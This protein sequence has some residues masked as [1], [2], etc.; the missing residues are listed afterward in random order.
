MDKFRLEM[1]AIY[2]VV[3]ED[4]DSQEA[5]GRKAS[6]AILR[7]ASR[8]SH[9]EFPFGMSVLAQLCACTNG[10]LTAIFP[11]DP[12]PVVLPVLNINLP[13]TRK[14]SGHR[15]GMVIGRQIDENVVDKAKRLARDLAA[16]HLDHQRVEAAARAV[17]VE[18][19]IM[20]SFTEA[21]FF[22]RCAGDWDQVKPNELHDLSGRVYFGTLV[23]L[24][25]AY[26]FLKMVG[27]VPQ[28]S[29][30]GVGGGLCWRARAGFLAAAVL[31]AVFPALVARATRRRLGVPRQGGLPRAGRR[32]ELARG[33]EG[34]C[35]RTER[36]GPPERGCGRGVRIEQA[37][38]NRRSS[39][40][41]EDRW[42][43]WAGFRSHRFGR[44][45]WKRTPCN[46]GADAPGLPRQ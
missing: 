44:H 39:D 17:R 45:Q 31:G 10:A 37:A 23:N 15:V 9:H 26:R 7:L 1:T 2:D 21:A 46:C 42:R 11:G 28:Q 6:Q 35:R 27:L 38:A 20:T 25:E 18:S 22:Q 16:E 19:S 32:W 41:H 8:A 12:C 5:L 29:P 34:T 14:S 36:R 13:Q 3:D 4:Y 33:L 43:L 24:D 30:K 40:D